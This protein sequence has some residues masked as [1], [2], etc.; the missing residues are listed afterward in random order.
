MAKNT[1]NGQYNTTKKIKIEQHELQVL[2]NDNHFF[3]PLMVSFVV[4]KCL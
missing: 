1:N 3:S 4:K 2:R